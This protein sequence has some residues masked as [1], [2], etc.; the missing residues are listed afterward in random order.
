[1]IE[2]KDAGDAIMSIAQVLLEHGIVDDQGC[3]VLQRAGIALKRKKHASDWDFEISVGE[4]VTF[5]EVP[6]GSG[7]AIRPRIM[8]RIA[9]D[10]S[11]QSKP[12]FTSLD[13]ALE[14]DD[15]T[16]NLLSR[17]HL[18]LANS[19]ADGWQD[20]PL[21]HLQYG[22]YS[23]HKELQV[24]TLSE[25]RWCHPPME[26]VLL[27][28][29]VAANFYRDKWVE[30]R[31]TPSWAGAIKLYERLCYTNYL[32]LLTKH[33]ATSGSPSALTGMWAGNWS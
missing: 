13:I 5:S 25:P 9:V 12:P 11:H 19:T 18:D 21:I 27:C 3:S 31:E 15:A 2:A 23:R 7:T 28:E 24:H 10:Q 29:L 4:P 16:A 26:I 33:L 22:G 30:F 32:A 8:A 1:V 20:G 17:W 6:S 14:I